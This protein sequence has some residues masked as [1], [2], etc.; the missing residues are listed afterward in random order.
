VG[1]GDRVIVEVEQDK[2]LPADA[3]GDPLDERKGEDDAA[4]G[5]GDR[6]RRGFCRNPKGAFV[7]VGFSR[8]R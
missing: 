8:K 7:A 3:D 6:R 4:K 2:G 5:M 1:I